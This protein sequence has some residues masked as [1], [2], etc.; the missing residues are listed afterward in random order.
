VLVRAA[1]ECGGNVLRLSIEASV[2]GKPESTVTSRR[3]NPQR[4]RRRRRAESAL[5]RMKRASRGRAVI[6][7]I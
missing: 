3:C 6:C 5:Q 7:A 2:A 4:R 1:K